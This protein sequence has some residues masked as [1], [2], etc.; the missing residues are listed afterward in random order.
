MTEPFVNNDFGA[1][2][3]P[4]YQHP[5]ILAA[6]ADG[7]SADGIHRVTLSPQCVLDVLAQRLGE[8]RADNPRKYLLICFSGAVSNRSAKRPPFFSGLGVARDLGM[9]IVAI[10]D[11][12]LGLSTH[13]GLAWYAGNDRI[14][15]LA[16]HLAELITGLSRSH[17]ARILMFGA[18]GGGFA[19][20]AVA[21]YLKCPATV[22]VWNPQTQIA[23]YAAESV[24]NYVRTAFP[25]LREQLQGLAELSA[26]D[27]ATSLGAAMERAGVRQ[28]VCGQNLPT[29]VELLY[30]QNRSDWHVIKH[31]GPYWRAQ[32]GKT[33]RIGNAGFGSESRQCCIFFGEWGVGHVAPSHSL[34][35][36]VLR[37]LFN[38]TRPEALVLALDGGVPGI[39]SP[40][41]FF[42]QFDPGGQGDFQVF[43][44][45]QGTAVWAKAGFTSHADE[46]IDGLQF[47]FYLLVDGKREAVRWYE[48]SATARFDLGGPEKGKLSVVAFA[49]DPFG[50]RITSS[51]VAVAGGVN[52]RLHATISGPLP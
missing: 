6:V 25:S 39:C 23:E 41:R 15:E 45:Q 43:A 47:A 34:I 7:L 31:A 9:P 49:M 37:E 36:F 13:L 48:P 46:S 32:K 11:P 1:W 21:E 38:G 4:V 8:W 44:A 30:L 51:V 27:R 18:S 50:N 17:E 28:N 26:R 14:A 40:A 5:S 24:E 33:S 20:M 2:N 29:S 16:K 52:P 3:C 10:S 42:P 22:A 12:S 19:A 35:L